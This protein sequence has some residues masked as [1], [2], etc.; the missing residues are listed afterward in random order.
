M[1]SEFGSKMERKTG[2]IPDQSE[3]PSKGTQFPHLD[4]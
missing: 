1:P 3:E 4:K 2:H